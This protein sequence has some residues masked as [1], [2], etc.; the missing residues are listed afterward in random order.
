MFPTEGFWRHPQ[1]GGEGA[2][3]TAK[4]RE[5]EGFAVSVGGFPREEEGKAAG[6]VKP[7]GGGGFHRIWSAAPSGRRRGAPPELQGPGRRRGLTV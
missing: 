7:K 6:T 1:G 5:E 2:A 4:P 3:R